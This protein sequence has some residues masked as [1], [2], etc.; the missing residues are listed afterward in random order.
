MGMFDGVV[1]EYDAARPSYPAALYDVLESTAGRL[2]SRAVLDAGAGTGVATRQLAER[3]A[4]VAAVDVGLTMLQRAVARSPGLSAV[5]ADAAA[6]PVRSASV[7]LVCFAQSWHWVPQAEGAA[8][9]ARVL[10]PGGWWA[11]W[12]SHPW[13]DDTPWWDAYQEVL[14]RSG[15]SYSRHQRDVDWAQEAVARQGAFVAPKRHIIPWDRTVTID[16]WITDLSSHSYVLALAAQ[17]RQQ[18]L[19][20]VHGILLT[21]FPANEMTVPYQTRLWLAARGPS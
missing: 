13:A 21:A 5:T 15:A 6:L 12:W 9:V 20:A 11:A 19:Q 1:D 10:R 4:R 2:R 3:G 14:E 18:L 16:A 8:E 17:A 7:D